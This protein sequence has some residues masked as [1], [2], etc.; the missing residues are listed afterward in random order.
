ME[1]GAYTCSTHQAS[2]SQQAAPQH[3]TLHSTSPAPGKLFPSPTL[4]P[5]AKFPEVGLLGEGATFSGQ[6]TLSHRNSCPRK[7][8][9]HLATWVSRSCF[10]CSNLRFS[11][12]CHQPASGPGPRRAAARSPPPAHVHHSLCREEAASYLIN[13]SHEPLALTLDSS[14]ISWVQGEPLASQASLT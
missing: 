8:D 5:K 9:P 10:I 7:P 14:P 6:H 12:F 2:S 11:S 13:H 3:P 1:G 4:I